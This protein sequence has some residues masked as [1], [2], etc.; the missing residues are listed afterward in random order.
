MT[1][2]NGDG[3]RDLDQII[4]DMEEALERLKSRRDADR[5]VVADMQTNIE[6]RRRR[7][8]F[9]VLVLPWGLGGAA[10]ATKAWLARRGRLSSAA[11]S[12]A[13]TAVATAAAFTALGADP[14]TNPPALAQP[15]PT[16]APPTAPSPSQTPPRS[17]PPV[18]P[19][20]HETP[21]PTG[22]HQP[23]PRGSGK[24][25]GSPPASS[26]PPPASPPVDP[27][28]SD[29]PPDDPPPPEDSA[30]P[31]IT[32]ACRIYLPHLGICLLPGRWVG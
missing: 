23:R 18:A 27:P 24:H 15:S 4:A 14:D 12:A 26:T 20:Q 25:P 1:R 19:P 5:A 11:A 17:K 8:A 32:T 9:K 29:D 31:V 3:P 28:P 22:T 2:P 6:A 7:R 13:V 21:P 16:A 10:A 30:S